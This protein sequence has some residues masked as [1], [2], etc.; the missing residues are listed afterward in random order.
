ME[1]EYIKLGKRKRLFFV[2]YDSDESDDS[3]ILIRKVSVKYLRRVV[4]DECFL[5][6]ME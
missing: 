6:E 2:M 3:D 1:D 4:E 5:L